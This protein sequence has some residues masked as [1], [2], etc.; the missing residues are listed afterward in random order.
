[1][2][3]SKSSSG[4]ALAHSLT[5]ATGLFLGRGRRFVAWA[6]LL[7][8]VGWGLYAAWHKWGRAAVQGPDFTFTPE[9]LQVTPQPTWIRA[10]VKAEVVRDSQLG[11]MRLLDP[12]LVEKIGRAF[13]LHAWVA[14]VR[15]VRKEYP[16]RV[17]VDVE[18]REP[19]AMVEVDAQQGPGLLFVDRDGV[20]L[21]SED[22]ERA[23][24]AQALLR[25]HVPRSE[26]AGPYGTAWGDPRIVGAARVAHAVR[27]VWQK[28]QLRRIHA[29]EVPGGQVI[30]EL[31]T[32]GDKHI[33]WGR[34]PGAEA[35]GEAAIEQKLKAL[36]ANVDQPP[37]TI[38]G[39]N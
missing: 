5:A 9:Q 32:K 37:A 39:L 21:P 17:I 10:D 25:I 23:S 38:D 18:Y 33:R 2:G 35:A 28:A 26:P 8:A 3:N 31:E 14:K 13:A 1:M 20:L 27:E 22:F 6:I 36:T 30:Y 16:A 29:L 15:Q 34:A 12:K 24:T 11:E 7:A 19:V 4:R